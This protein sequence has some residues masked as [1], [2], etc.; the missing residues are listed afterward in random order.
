[1]CRL[2]R[3]AVAVVVGPRIYERIGHGEFIMAARSEVDAFGSRISDQKLHHTPWQT[4][5]L[6][7][8]HDVPGQMNPN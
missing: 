6:I 7:S 8:P 2:K 3:G 4:H 5:F 1:M